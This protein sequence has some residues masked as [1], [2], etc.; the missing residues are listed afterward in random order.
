M[1]RSWLVFLVIIQL[2]NTL[3]CDVSYHLVLQKTLDAD[4]MFIF[5]PMLIHCLRRWH[6][7]K[8]ILN[9]L[10]VF[11]EVVS[12]LTD[13]TVHTEKAMTGKVK[14]FLMAIDCIAEV[15]K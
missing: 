10:V 3:C 9:Q 12:G 11:A 8:Y 4:P 6:N 14:Y 15:F 1:I 5:D 2:I 7:I 13:Y